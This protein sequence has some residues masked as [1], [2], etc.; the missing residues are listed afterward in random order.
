[1]IVEFLMGG[2]GFDWLD[3]LVFRAAAA[4]F[5][6]FIL[7]MALGRPTIAWLRSLRRTRRSVPCRG[8]CGRGR[9]AWTHMC[10]MQDGRP[11]HTPTA[12]HIDTL[13]PAH[14]LELLLHTH[15]A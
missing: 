9:G 15:A 3:S 14:G 2:A 4:A 5:T 13:R 6:A 8:T 10:K 12:A 1:M 7:A 11:R